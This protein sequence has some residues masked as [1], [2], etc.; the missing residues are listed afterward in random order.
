MRNPLKRAT[1]WFVN[2]HAPLGDDFGSIRGKDRVGLNQLIE[3]G[4]EHAQGYQDAEARLKLLD[5]QYNTGQ[6]HEEDRVDSDLQLKIAAVQE[7]GGGSSKKYTRHRRRTRK[8]K[9]NI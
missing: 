5:R 6:P 1:S 4:D 7:L 8:N 3:Q 9:I 2:R